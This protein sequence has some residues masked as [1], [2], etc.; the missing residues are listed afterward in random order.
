[1]SDPL[2]PL[3]E[4]IARHGLLAK[5]GLGQNFLLDLNLTRRIARAARPLEGRTVIEIGPGPGG[6]TRGLLLE[7]A[8]R[9]IAIERDPRAIPAIAE[10]SAAYPGRL[11]VIAGD[12]LEIVWN[13]VAVRPA[14][15]VSNLPYNIAT[16]LLVGWLSEEEWPPWYQSLTLMFQREVA[17]RITAVPGSKAYGRLS[18]LAQWRAKAIKLFDVDRMAFTP[19]PKVQSSLVQITPLSPLDTRCRVSDLAQI[20]Q[21]AFGQRRKKLRSSLKR[22][23]ADAAATI[24]DLGIDPD[25]RP[26]H[27]GV[28][29]FCRLAVAFRA[30]HAT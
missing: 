21:L 12:A 30:G 7:G 14:K 13:D 1:V 25:R 26:E 15:V 2:P 5:K 27:V 16:A 22:L 10:I 18:I 17:Q 28:A 24:K 3:R 9:I 11:Q 23:A 8:E 4:V 19:P 20:T 6:L 29:D